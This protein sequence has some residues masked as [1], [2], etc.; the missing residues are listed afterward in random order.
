MS[1]AELDRAAGALL[2]LA[3]GDALGA[4]YEF[5]VPGPGAA[6]E[7]HAGGPWQLG[8][9]TDDTAQ[10][11]AIAEVAAAGRLDPTGDDLRR[12]GQRF[13]DWYADGPKDVGI[14]TSA[15]L[16]AAGGDPA[17]LP[18]A[19]AAYF[20]RY[21]RGAAGNGSLMRTAPVA[22]AHL[23]DD[24]A[25]TRAATET[26]LLTHG[27]PLAAEGCV[28]WC[29]AI[30]RAVREQRLDGVHDGL[31][32]L[33]RERGGWWDA[34]LAEAESSDPHGFSTGN[35]FVVTALQAAH[36]VI[37]QT[38][39]P[40]Q[41]SARHLQDALVEAVRIGND[42][43]TVAA[44]AGQVLGAR[45][46]ASAVPWAWRRHLHGW[47]GLAADDL[48]RLGVLAA[49]DGAPDAIGW[50]SVDSLADWARTQ[51]PVPLCVPLEA[52]GPD[53]HGGI[54]IGNLLG[55]DEAVSRGVDAVVSLCRV[56]RAEV[57]TGVEHATFWL[58]DQVAEEANPN[59][60]V[61]VE[62]AA[63]AV[64]D[65]RREGRRVFLHCVGGRSRTPTVAA[66]YLADRDDSSRADAVERLRATLP[67]VDLNPR[68]RGLLR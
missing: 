20:D 29:I 32:L 48:V 12:V 18:D 16:R 56:G 40:A 49:R 42:T 3:A 21:P 4:P 1:G 7:L 14:S 23:G 39:V 35:G 15:V 36:A 57:P 33:P 30:D 52:S 61:V 58:V 68:F 9:W 8:E 45:W 2:G 26:S 27:D 24:R 65:L 34:R 31:A 67:E 13:L 60:E 25:I 66:T 63:R 5:S 37:A 43:D 51:E 46:G 11:V 28:L 10:A 62:D 54:L 22:L 17:R 59:L 47:P 55:I 19:A 41:R 38:P 44:I 64:A 50:P 6:I 53:A